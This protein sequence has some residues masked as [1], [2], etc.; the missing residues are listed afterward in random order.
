MQSVLYNQSFFYLSRKALYSKFTIYSPLL[1]I[2]V[3]FARDCKQLY[4]HIYFNYFYPIGLG[5]VGLQGSLSV[6]TL[7]LSNW[8]E[9]FSILYLTWSIQFAYQVLNHSKIGPKMPMLEDGAL[10]DLNAIQMILVQIHTQCASS[11]LFSRHSMTKLFL[12]EIADC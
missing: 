10:K 2:S 6:L 1:K 9:E 7:Q 12:I 3:V 8:T 5:L 11:L 4:I